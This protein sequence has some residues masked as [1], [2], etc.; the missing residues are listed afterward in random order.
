MTNLASDKNALFIETKPKT[1]T[2][3]DIKL[4]NIRMFNEKINS[5]RTRNGIYVLDFV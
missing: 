3:A 4:S 1:W 5:S 2:I